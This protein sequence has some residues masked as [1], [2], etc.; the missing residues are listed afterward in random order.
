MR[1]FIRMQLIVIVLFSISFLVPRAAGLPWFFA[2]I[3]GIVLPI[4]IDIGTG[5]RL[6]PSYEQGIS[7]WIGIMTVFLFYPA[8]PLF[9]SGIGIDWWSWPLIMAIVCLVAGFVFTVRWVS[10]LLKEQTCYWLATFALAAEVTIV[11][12]ILIR[13]LRGERLWTTSL[14]ALAGIIAFLLM[15]RLTQRNSITPT[16]HKR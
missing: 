1:Q 13:D 16:V 11:M 4:C 14:T 2:S 6:T 10:H 3:L 9:F 12:S 5:R 15:L 7:F 8:I